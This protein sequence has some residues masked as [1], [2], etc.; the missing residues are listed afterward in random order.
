MTYFLLRY[1]CVIY[2]FNVVTFFNDVKNRFYLGTFELRMEMTLQVRFVFVRHCNV[3]F[4]TSQ[5]R[6]MFVRCS[7]VFLMTL[8]L[9]F[10]LVGSNYVRKLHYKMVIF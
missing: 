5:L 1:N 2:L 10:I 9:R 7:Y 4:I 6:Y 8:E 3:C